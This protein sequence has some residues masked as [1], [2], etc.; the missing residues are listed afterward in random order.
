[1]YL[2]SW[3]VH[4]TAT[5]QPISYFKS[6]V[7]AKICTTKLFVVPRMGKKHVKKRYKSQDSC[8]MFMNSIEDWGRNP[9][10]RAW[11]FHTLDNSMPRPWTFDDCEYQAWFLNFS[12]ILLS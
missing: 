10:S 8:L 9:G 1:M 4:D 12:E 11:T 5:V 7:Q 2:A 6:K 3:G